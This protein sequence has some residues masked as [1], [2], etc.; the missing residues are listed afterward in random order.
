MVVMVITIS[1]TS[2]GRSQEI[3]QEPTPP[4]A[5][6]NNR[7]HT[8]TQACRWVRLRSFRRSTATP[9]TDTKS[10]SD[11]NS[12]DGFDGYLILQCH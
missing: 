10:V 8:I 4:T 12:S 6:N 2:N 5:T 1:S 11:C 9:V 7:H 3:V